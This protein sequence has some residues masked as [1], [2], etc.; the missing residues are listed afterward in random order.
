MERGYRTCLRA[1]CDFVKL[2]AL[3][4]L[5]LSVLQ[6]GFRPDCLCGVVSCDNRL[7]WAEGA[8][9]DSWG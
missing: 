1:S 9:L 6:W 5:A 4:C 3:G 8:W 7:A 2:P